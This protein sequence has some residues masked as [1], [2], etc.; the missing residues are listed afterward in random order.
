MIPFVGV[1]HNGE[2]PH[3]FGW[4]LLQLNPDIRA[5]AAIAIDIIPWDDEDIEWAYYGNKLW[6]NFAKYG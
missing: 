5:D 1:P 4:P 2:L 6:T 3:V